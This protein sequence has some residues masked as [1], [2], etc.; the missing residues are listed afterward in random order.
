MDLTVRILFSAD[1]PSRMAI[2][3]AVTFFHNGLGTVID[4]HVTFDGEALVMQHVT[5]GYSMVG[6]SGVPHIGRRV[7]IGAGASVLGGVRIG[8][9][10]VIGAGAVVTSDLPTGHRTT[11]GS[12][13]IAPLEF[14]GWLALWEP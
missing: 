2:P 6:R 11:K 9:D 1:I 4:A 5:L 12:V 3:D 13:A 8:D 10:C 7:I 14:D